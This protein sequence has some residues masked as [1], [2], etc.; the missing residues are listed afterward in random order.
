[1]R[2]RFH[3]LL[4][5]S[6]RVAT[7]RDSRKGEL[8]ALRSEGDFIKGQAADLYTLKLTIETLTGMQR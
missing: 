4:S 6:T 1:V 3:T 7:R 2:N 5:I 8:H